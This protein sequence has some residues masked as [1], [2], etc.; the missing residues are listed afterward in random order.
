MAKKSNKRVDSKVVLLVF[1]VLLALGIVFSVVGPQQ[2]DDPE[3]AMGLYYAG[4]CMSVLFG[5]L[6]GYTFMMVL[7][8]NKPF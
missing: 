8:G 2:L 1:L 4:V 5:L 3:L 6:F 7:A